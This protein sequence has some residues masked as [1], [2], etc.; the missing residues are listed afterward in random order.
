MN[1][2]G[3]TLIELVGVVA[4]IALIFLIIF[5]N[6]NNL[7]KNNDAKEYETYEK[8]MVE[9]T[10]IIPSYQNK[11]CVLLSDLITKY[12][13]K[14]INDKIECDGYVMINNM[15][16]YLKCIQNEVEVYKTEG[17]NLSSCS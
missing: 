9:Y 8:I 2:E 1:K 14:K 5:P 13:L 15:K 10:K 6:L 4:L 7:R 12:N 3:F 17:Y 11:A 16:P